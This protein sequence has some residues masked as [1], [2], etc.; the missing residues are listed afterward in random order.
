MLSRARG[1]ANLSKSLMHQKQSK[2]PRP[3][4][5]P[6]AHATAPGQK[7]ASNTE[8]GNGDCLWGPHL[9]GH[10][11]SDIVHFFI[12]YVNSVGWTCLGYSEFKV[13]LHNLVSPCCEYVKKGW[14]QNHRPACTL[15][16]CPPGLA[17]QAH[18]STTLKILTLQSSSGI[19][20]VQG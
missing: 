8:V 13:S 2:L 9:G 4:P 17:L 1:G 16:C 15:A 10:P 12:L 3:R 20:Q 18:K 5:Y 7:P 19:H 14:V 6:P 11:H